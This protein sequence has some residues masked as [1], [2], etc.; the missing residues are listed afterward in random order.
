MKES[1][2]HTPSELY[3]LT[4]PVFFVGFMGAG[5]TSVSRYLSRRCGLAS[6]DLDRYLAR[7]EG[8]S[9]KE[10]FLEEGEPLSR[11]GSRAHRR[12]AD[13]ESV[14]HFVCG[15]GHR[16]GSSSVAARSC[17]KMGFVVHLQVDPAESRARIS[18][19]STRPY[20]DSDPEK[21]EEMNRERLPLYR[22][23]ALLHRGDA[24]QFGAC[25]RPVG[26]IHS[27][28]EGICALP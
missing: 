18:D 25:Q 3:R 15:S 14:A 17:A 6:V 21:I 11:H 24:G 26:R 8:R 4:E 5:K 22:Q 13:R 10:L 19:H 7:R 28:E 27:S 23:A 12:T 1:T 2:S 16:H 9:A 20:L